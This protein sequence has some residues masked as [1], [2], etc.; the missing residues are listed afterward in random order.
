MRAFNYNDCTDVTFQR[1]DP[2]WEEFVDLDLESVLEVKEKIRAIITPPI[3]TASCSALE[4]V[5]FSP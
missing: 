4:C 2:E 1:Y 5:S 3:T